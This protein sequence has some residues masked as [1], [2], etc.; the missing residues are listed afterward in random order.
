[1]WPRP[2]TSWEAER[3][4]AR[5]AD[6][7]VGDVLAVTVGHAGSWPGI[8]PA[9]DLLQVERHAQAELV[10]VA[11]G[12]VVVVATVEVGTHSAT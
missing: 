2:Q 7:V 9:Q 12:L 11:R 10:A 3:A 8:V 1:M 6:A 4:G 5:V